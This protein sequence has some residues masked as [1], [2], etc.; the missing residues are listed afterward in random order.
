[1]FF[2]LLLAVLFL[3]EGCVSSPPKSDPALFFGAH[4]DEETSLAFKRALTLEAGS[5]DLEQARIDY[6]LERIGKSPY[7]FIRNKSRY[8]GKRAQ[9]HLRWKY[10]FRNRWRV[11]T[12]Q[13]FINW[14]ATGSKRTGEPYLVEFPDRKRYPMRTLLLNELQFFDQL[15]D[16]RKLEIKEEAKRKAESPPATEEP[17]SP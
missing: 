2:L 15:V 11:K 3:G 17:K 14:V 5:Q 7:N 10:F 6:L 9:A 8:T 12:A 16:K 13:D 1:M 4:E